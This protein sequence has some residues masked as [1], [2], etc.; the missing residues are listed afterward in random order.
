MTGLHQ[1]LNQE[2][3]HEREGAVERLQSRWSSSSQVIVDKPPSHLPTRRQMGGIPS[4]GSVKE[5]RHTD[6]GTGNSRRGQSNSKW[7]SGSGV[8]D[9]SPLQPLSRRGGR[10]ILESTVL[11]EPVVP[12][13]ADRSK[14]STDKSY[15]GMALTDGRYARSYRAINA[16]E[17][18]GG[19]ASCA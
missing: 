7:D 10:E 17:R 4:S 9:S 14:D 6:A 3:G 16:G 11:L 13:N 18:Q 1:R 5:Y 19:A 12:V 2:N 15:G 8:T